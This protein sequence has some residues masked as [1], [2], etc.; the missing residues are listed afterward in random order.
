MVLITTTKNLKLEK[1]KLALKSASNFL[2]RFRFANRNVITQVHPSGQDAVR[3][4]ESSLFLI[5]LP[6]R[7]TSCHLNANLLS[8]V[9]YCTRGDG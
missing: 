6:L 4:H 2:V 7:A 8:S 1:W 9:R 5:I 3:T